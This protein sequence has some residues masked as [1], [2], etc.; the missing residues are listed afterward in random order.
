MAWF[1]FE[2][3]NTY[4]LI[5]Y[6]IQINK[7]KITLGE[8]DCL[9]LENKTLIHL[10]ISY[11]FYIVDFNVGTN[12]IDFCIGPNKRD[13]LK[14]KI[15]KILIQQFPIIE[16]DETKK[17]I[18]NLGIQF[19]EIVQKVLFKAQLFLPFTNQNYEFKFLNNN[20]IAGF[21]INKNELYNLEDCKFYIPF[22]KDWLLDPFLNVN[23]ISFTDFLK[24]V[25]NFYKQKNA[26]L[27]W[28]KQTNGN[29]Q[30]A[31]LV[32]W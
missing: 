15:N 30:K 21:Y 2:N 23:W 32:W 18:K 29:L 28:I 22:K 24:L 8:I 16:S 5:D 7:N 26:P 19:N 1:E 17:Y 25:E 3:T 14:D 31:F 4:E 20:C 13:C 6:N 27:I 9:L 12:E 10:E 11:K